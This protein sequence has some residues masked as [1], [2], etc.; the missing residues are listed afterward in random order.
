MP[1][2]KYTHM[3]KVPKDIGKVTQAY[4]KLQTEANIRSPTSVV[5]I[6]IEFNFMSNYEQK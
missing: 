1:N 3:I 6:R 4:V 2:S 5:I